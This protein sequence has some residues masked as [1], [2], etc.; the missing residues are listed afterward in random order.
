MCLN[1]TV[2]KICVAKHLFDVFPILGGLEQ[3]DVLSP[4]L[5]NSALE[6]AIR[7]IQ[8][9]RRLGT[10]L[11]TSGGLSTLREEHRLRVFENRVLREYFYLRG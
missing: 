4:F 10:E 1:E 7:K 5:F 3:G 9:Q 6:Y 11:E 2:I 8:K